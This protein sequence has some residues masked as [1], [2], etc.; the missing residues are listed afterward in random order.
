MLFKNPGSTPKKNYDFGYLALVGTLMVLGILVLASASGP[1]G[2][3][4]FNDSYWF[5]KHQLLAGV[6][7]GA[8]GFLLFFLINPDFWRRNWKLLY[9]FGVLLLALPF[10]PVL[11]NNWGTARSWIHIGNSSF[12]TSELAKLIGIMALAGWLEA[13]GKIAVNDLKQGFFTFI[14]GLGVMLVLLILQP[15]VG[16]M[17]VFALVAFAVYFVAGGKLSY[18]SALIS[19]GGLMFWLLIKA[20]PY[21]AERFMVFLHPELDPK[22]LGYHINQA[23]M[24]I[25]SGGFFGLGFGHSRQKYQYLPEV[26]GDSVFAVMAEE[27]GFIPVAIIIGLIIAFVY[28][29]VAIARKLDEFGKFVTIGVAV[30]ISGQALVNIGSMIGLMPMTGLTLPFVS[31]GGSSFFALACAAGLVF[32]MSGAR[33]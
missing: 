18:M 22:G 14:G 19:A 26:A 3:Q 29:S 1:L 4:K 31:Y 7:P 25:G 13:R 9:V 28:R 5:L 12:Q 6:L 32:K 10:L 2:F 11:G 23:L 16:G 27:L 15:D 17:A 30:W 33:R 20:R 21:R 8:F 24:T